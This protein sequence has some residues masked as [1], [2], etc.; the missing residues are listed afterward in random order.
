[1]QVVSV[2]GSGFAKGFAYIVCIFILGF[3][4]QHMEVLVYREDASKL[5]VAFFFHVQVLFKVLFFFF[6]ASSSTTNLVV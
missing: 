3:R 6:L 4:E 2:G 5:Q 1:M